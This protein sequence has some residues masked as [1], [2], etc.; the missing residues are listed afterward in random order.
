MARRSTVVDD[1]APFA[2][3]PRPVRR[4]LAAHTDVL[5]PAAG[6]VLARQGAVAREVVVIVAG[7][8]DVEHD[9]R[10]AAPLGPGGWFGGEE[11]LHGDPHRC[12]ITAREGVDLRVVNGPA[13]RAAAAHLP[14]PGR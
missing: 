14:P 2:S 5:R 7:E 8:V 13:F 1:L 12:T 11:V 10:P 6:T 4:Q 3:C 9:G